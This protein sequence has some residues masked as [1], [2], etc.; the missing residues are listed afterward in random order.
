MR[1]KRIFTEEEI[2]YIIDNWGKESTYSMRKKFDCSFEAICK[3]AVKNG[4]EKPKSN[5]WTEE[6]INTL[7]ELS[8]KFHYQD[9]AKIMGKSENAI[10]L[11]ARKL[12]IILIQD[13]RKWTK[14][15][16]EQLKDLWGSKSIEYI[17]RKLKRTVFSLKVKA[18]RMSL[19]PMIRNA[20]DILTIYDVVDLINVSRDRI[21][22][23]WVKLGL[24]L[25]KK[26]LT[27]NTSYYFVEWDDLIEFLEKNQNEWDSRNLEP[28]MLGDEF[29]WLVEKRKRD[30]DANPLWY[31]YWTTK[32]LKYAEHLFMVNKSD[33]EI[34]D[35]LQRTEK[36]IK[37]L[38]RKFG[39]KSS[40]F[41]TENEIEYLQE[42]FKTSTYEEI[43]KK[44]GRTT[45]AVGYKAESLG[46]QKVIKK[47]TN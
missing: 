28:Y 38:R 18:V 14:Q 35:I 6:E 3:V 8:D 27:K 1:E 5:Q 4:L 17:A 16:E 21:T 10:Y 41:W 34:A 39:Y 29:D 19:G 40:V 46:F 37:E 24:K 11:K 36:A 43:S 25:N 30:R 32:D 9:I 23:T 33:K 13:R 44:L 22:T 2:N 45:K 42:N 12:G 7:K 31:R 26:K 15:E 20:T 47:S